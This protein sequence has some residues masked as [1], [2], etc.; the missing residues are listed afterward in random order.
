MKLLYLLPPDDEAAFRAA[1]AG[2]EIIYCLPYDIEDGKL[3]NGYT[4]FT[5]EAIY[6]ILN[7]EVKARFDFDFLEDFTVDKLYG[8][9]AFCAKEHGVDREICR[10]TPGSNQPRYASLLSPCEQM[11]L[12]HFRGAEPNTDPELVC[13]RCG[14]PYIPHT[15]ICRFCTKNRQNYRRL[16]AATKGLRLMML[17]PFVVTAVT[18]V[19]RFVVPSLQKTALNSYIY[20]VSGVERGPIEKFF[21]IVA[22]LI[23]LDLVSRLLGA[24]ESRLSGV[25]GN[26]FFFLLRQVLFEKVEQLSLAS[27][28]RRTVGHL[29]AR[30]NGDVQVVT[31][32]LISRLPALFSQVLSLFVGIFLIL[33]ISPTMSLLVAIP[34][35]LAF[36]FIVLTR[37]I[38]NHQVLCHRS[39]S[40]RYG[41]YLQDVFNGERVI[42]SFGHENKTLAEHSTLL[43]RDTD[44]SVRSGKMSTFFSLIT[45][46]IYDIGSYLLL[47]F[48]NLW[49]FQGAMDVGTINQ[50]YVYTGII[51][52]PLRQFA[53]VPAEIA[54]FLTALGQIME[55]FDEEIEVRDPEAPLYPEIQGEIQVKD[56]T[57]GY[58]AYEPVLKHVSVEIHQGEMVG[59]VGHSGC[60]KSTLVNLI[61]RLYDVNKGEIEIDGVNV[62]KMP[63]GYLRSAI[64]VVP[65]E[66]Q[67]FDGT[68]RENIRYSKP[69]ATE[70][71][72]IIAAKA[73]NAHDFIL[74]LPQGYN[75]RVG[76]KGYSLSGGE[77]QRVAIARALIHD[78]KILILDE[79]TA[80]LDTETEKA[81]QE[82]IDRLTDGR[83]TIAIAHRLS[84][85]RNADRIV[86]MDQGRVIE[87]GSH[88]E[89]LEQRGRYYKLVSA[90]AEAALGVDAV[91]VGVLS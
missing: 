43:G 49:L 6:R 26:R 59:I 48:G 58:N 30:I 72:V 32:F 40:Q 36:L 73:A 91:E 46:Q 34:F 50:F 82:A 77:R 63:Q 79:A 84:T 37:K 3:V 60:G 4:V 71:Q 21:A 75:T 74:S 27:I 22:A 76:D 42:K 19:I 45:A 38:I 68:V 9:C 29:S 87:A 56:I 51:Y 83:T 61:M 78:P 52:E 65:Q 1:A 28:Q 39:S 5:P 62:R 12:H 70:E 15:Q 14:M 64:G 55:I 47:F 53:A 54:N 17:F 35:P 67:L 18:L 80:S 16:F 41:W 57:F 31:D 2:E 44:I 23:V 86:V 25:A 69:D 8:C 66:T 90:Q 20:P 81:I 11:A 7:G 89:L 33:Y 13:P 85:L 24:L 88:H 10:F